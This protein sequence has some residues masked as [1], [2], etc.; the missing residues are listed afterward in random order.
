MK[1]LYKILKRRIKIKPGDDYFK[2]F[3][4]STW[5]R[6]FLY[7]LITSTTDLNNWIQQY[8]V[9]R[10]FYR[11]HKISIITPV[12]NTP[13]DILLECVNSVRYQSNPNWEMILFDDA[14][15]N[16]DTKQ[17]LKDIK[18]YNDKRI[19]IFSHKKNHG[20]CIT[21]NKAAKKASGSYLAIL[22]HDDILCL[23]ALFEVAKRL[24][25][26]T[27]LVIYSDRDKITNQHDRYEP[28]IKPDWA[29]E[30]LLSVNYIFHLV[31]IN[32]KFFL[33]LGGYRA[34]Y[35]GSQDFDFLLRF[36]SKHNDNRYV[37]HISKVL[38]SWRAIDSSSSI[39]PCAKQFIYDSGVNALK[40]HFFQ[41]GIDVSVSEMSNIWRG[42]YKISFPE[43]DHDQY[44][45]FTLDS[46]DKCASKIN[47]VINN[48]SK[49][50]I[51]FISPYVEASEQSIR[52]MIQPM[53]IEGV[54]LT[55]GKV[56]DSNNCIKYSGIAVL[57]NYT[58]QFTHYGYH[59]DEPGYLG[60]NR[61]L[62]NV[63]MVYPGCF[64]V[65]KEA[66]QKANGLNESYAGLYAIF[67]FC[68][69]VLEKHFRIVIDPEAEFKTNH[70][71]DIYRYAEDISKF[72]SI[73]K[74]Q[75]RKGDPYYS[76]FF[77]H[78]FNDGRLC[79]D[80]FNYINRHV[81]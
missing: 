11:K 64:V 25:K 52:K 79:T 36:M 73:W 27:A 66:W 32:R 55:T 48:S 59:G 39:D 9:S 56:I 68:Y 75:I 78:E 1:L 40:S 33:D 8:V 67:D 81:K 15:T 21:T 37:S 14:S 4:S 38:Y 41:K 28:Q 57:T 63:S 77:S 72:N 62:H 30:T 53:I 50:Y 3:C 2:E 45:V 42:Y 23:N 70:T 6:Y 71:L 24:K 60:Y 44:E 69:R 29:P 5:P 47:S 54:G 76:R 34:E 61:I 35:E 13:Y 80:N 20:I 74:K 16:D 19:K 22:D 51:V 58:L 17:C 26:K 10:I 31:I 46:F 7:I 49:A 43:F 18:S 65:N 12:Y